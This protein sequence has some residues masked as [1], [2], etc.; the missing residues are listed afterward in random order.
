MN[1]AALLT[2]QAQIRPHQPAIIDFSQHKRRVLTFVELEQA[3]AHSAGLF[4]QAGLQVGDVV[5]IFQPMS[6]ELYIALAG[7]FRLGLVAMF[8]DPG[9]GLRHIAQCCAIQSPKAVLASQKAL[10]LLALFPAVRRIP[11]KFSVRQYS[12][13]VESQPFCL[14]DKARFLSAPKLARL[15]GRTRSTLPQ[16]GSHPQCFSAQASDPAL[17][18][19][20]SGSTGQPKAALRSHGFLWCQHQAIA[21]CLALSP[22]SVSLAT[23]PIVLL[24][25]LAQGITSVIPGGDLRSPGKID[26]APLVAWMQAENVASTVASPAL[27]QRLADYCQAQQYSLPSLQKIFTG[28]APVFPKTLQR[29]QQ[30]APQAEVVT[31][32]GSTEAEPMAK[33]ALNQ[34]QT[35][36]V[37][38]ML[39]GGGLLVGMPVPTIHL[40]ILPDSWGKPL[41]PMS[42]SEFECLQCPRGVVGEIVVSG[43]HVL[44]GYLHGKGDAESKFRVDGSSW[45]RTGDA[46]YLDG[47]GRLWL[48][49][50]CSARLQDER[51]VVY[52]FAVECA[53]S[54]LPALQRS[55]FLSHD[56]RR[57]LV[58]EV[59]DASASW[60][61]GLKRTRFPFKKSLPSMTTPTCRDLP[62]RNWVSR[63]CEQLK[64]RVDWAG[65]DEIRVFKHIPLD[66]RHNAKVDYP[67]LHKQLAGWRRFFGEVGWG[68]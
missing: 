38:A 44:S 53:L 43:A 62:S 8:I 6:A 49:G 45:H 26:P 25:N 54:Q 14:K 32:Y 20:T 39:A 41:A 48:M 67:A 58:V 12:A 37:Q 18:T 30:V 9:Q 21:E 11:F 65:V 35:A 19:F 24:S 36:D 55:A 4:Q 61:G 63:N 64:A 2:D 22:G 50:R 3:A 16:T 5:L 52:P 47:Q 10:H 56:A 17:L 46:G 57:V 28:G 7:I 40:A 31:I 15:G 66:V 1:I 33:I 13:Q 42:Q 60:C 34:V 23:M 27:L 68:A 59:A 51:G 29:L